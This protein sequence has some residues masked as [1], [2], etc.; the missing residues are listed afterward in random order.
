MINQF[1]KEFA[2]FFEKL[3]LSRN[4][5]QE[6]FTKDVVSMRQYRRYIRGECLIPQYVVNKL[7]IRL[8]F[9]PE[10]IISEFDSERIRESSMVSSFYNAVANQDYV[11]VKQYMKSITYDRLLDD[12]NKLLYNHSVNYYKHA[13][14][15]ISD[16]EI[17]KITMDALNY[18]TIL[19]NSVFSPV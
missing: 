1:S 6:Q 2:L 11:K 10:H 4:L 5:T 9:K 17:T 3:R 16:E 13:V 15:K 8:G 14:G 19:K 7:S 12:Q 18:K